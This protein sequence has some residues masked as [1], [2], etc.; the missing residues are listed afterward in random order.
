M[1]FYHRYL[2]VIYHFYTKTLKQSSIPLLY[3]TS[4]STTFLFINF[5]T[6]YGLSVYNNAFPDFINSTSMVL[7]IVF[8]I[9]VL[10]YFLFI[11]SETFMAYHSE[12][13]AKSSLV[14]VCYI[15]AT[16][17]AFIILANKNREK[18]HKEQVVPYSLVL[19]PAGARF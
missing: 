14:T 17:L 5:Y 7:I 16:V 8:A 18:I 13:H 19:P 4:V 15:I 2:Y 10:N 3:I 12:K 9:G 1:A 6:I 11:R